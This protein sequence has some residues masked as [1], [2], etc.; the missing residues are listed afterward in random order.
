MVTDVE[1]I[2]VPDAP[3]VAGLRFR[4]YRGVDADVPA[5]HAVA[6]AVRIADGEVEPSSLEGMK[7]WYRHLERC[8]PATDIAVVEVEGR[9]VGYVRVEWADT[10]EGERHYE[11]NWFLVP[12]F[13]GGG[14][15]STMLRWAEGRIREIAAGHRAAGDGAARPWWLTIGVYDGDARGRRAI[16]DLGYAPFRRFHSMVRPDLD[17]LSAADLPPG[18][19]VRPVPNDRDAMRRVFMA[20]AEAFRD[21]FGWVD[22]S[23]D[24]FLA[25]V[26]DPA[27]NPRLW[28]VAFDGAEIAGGVLNGIH[29]L[30]D[31]S[32]QGWLDSVF[33]RRPWRRRGLARAL[34]AR[35]LA[36]LREEG[37]TAAYLG[38]DSENANQALG[39]YESAGFQVASSSTAYRKLLE[40]AS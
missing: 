29:V 27:T 1:T 30:E 6:E 28:Q 5:M 18:L 13:R 20:D 10:N 7:A 23:E 25:F 26:E 9:V 12:E 34:I 2:L 33:T 35:S 31:G 14:L 16:L 4:H 40:D 32:R 17:G 3:P 38:V 19:E 22:E 21:H 37:M 24:A 36:V 11:T 39:L 15:G 8:D